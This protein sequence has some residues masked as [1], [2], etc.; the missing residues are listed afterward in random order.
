[1]G[2]PYVDKNRLYDFFDEFKKEATRETGRFPSDFS[3]RVKPVNMISRISGLWTSKP[4]DDSTGLRPNKMRPKQDPN[5]P[6]ITN[7]KIESHVV[8][9]FTRGVVA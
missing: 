4:R 3:T 9:F 8:A 6:R 5:M 2:P 7:Q 1:M